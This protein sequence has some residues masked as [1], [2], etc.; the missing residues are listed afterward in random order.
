[1]FIRDHIIRV[2]E[3]AFD[4]FAGSGASREQMRGLLGIGETR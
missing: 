3:R 2:G 1:V 4:D